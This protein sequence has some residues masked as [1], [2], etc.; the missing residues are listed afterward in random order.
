MVWT[1]FAYIFFWVAFFCLV[2]VIL[3][4]L[5]NRP[6]SASDW[7]KKISSRFGQ[8]PAETEQM[9]GILRRFGVLFLAAGMLFLLLSMPTGEMS[10]ED[11]GKL[12]LAEVGCAVVVFWQIKGIRNIVKSQPG[13][14]ARSI[15]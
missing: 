14:G 4:S 13:R 3:I 10:A 12:T 5:S 2:L 1:L 9:R 15:K 8:T 11:Q 7:L 6:Q